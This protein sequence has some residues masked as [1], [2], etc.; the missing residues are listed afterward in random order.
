MEHSRLRTRVGVTFLEG[1]ARWTNVSAEFAEQGAKK[2]EELTLR[3]Q[4]LERL[5]W[6]RERL[7][8]HNWRFGYHTTG[9]NERD[10]MAPDTII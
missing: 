5:S 7:L 1:E 4:S 3:V 8:L 2:I 6:G 10:G 9:R